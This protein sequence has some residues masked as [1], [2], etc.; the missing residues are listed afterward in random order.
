MTRIKALWTEGSLLSRTIVHV[1]SFVLVSLAFVSATSFAL[2]SVTKG[3]LSARGGAATSRD[4]VA[5]L[6]LPVGTSAARAAAP[7][8]ATKAVRAVTPRVGAG[9]DD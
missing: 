2:V 5:Q 8:P 7:K 9:G 6:A 4:D 1:A 3:L